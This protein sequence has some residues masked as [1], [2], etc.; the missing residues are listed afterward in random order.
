M[1][2]IWIWGTGLIAEQVLAQ[3]DVFEMYEVAGFI[4]N[5]AAKAGKSFHG[6]QICA[7]AAL[8]KE[9]ADRIVILTVY[10]REIEKQI[11]R[12]FPDLTASVEGMNFFYRQSVRK[13]YRDSSDPE[14]VQIL[15]YLKT[16][17]LQVFNYDF[18]NKYEE[19]DPMIELDEACGMYYTHHEGKRLY[20]AQSLKTVEEVKK[21]YKGVLME[22]DVESPHRYTDEAFCVEQGDV[23]V[24]VGVAE[25][26]FSLQV[27]DLASKLYLIETDEEWVKALR[28]TF[29]PYG[30]KVVIIEKF[31]T[32]LDEGR[33]S[34][35]DSMIEEPVNFIKMD[36]EGNEWDAL[37]GA[38]KLIE[39]SEKLKCAVCAYH[40][41][42]DEILIKD[43]FK[44]Y[45]ME[46]S[47]TPGYMWYSDTNRQTY[48]STRLCRGI[49]RGIKD[50][51]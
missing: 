37:L 12:D 24:D 50:S 46:T 18:T 36:I 6:R 51:N 7:P 48:V 39:R 10:W 13:R 32:S 33:Y 23:I 49:V 26:N 40:G 3:C 45:E 16:N 22:Q 17:D 41:D 25:G 11:R 35:L 19:M 28:E 8:R 31:A 29:R 47:V 21:Y 30:D 14:I 9:N 20:F 42:F 5:D 4:D 2:K 43:A 1:E 44:K 27:V 15:K 34:T 38:E